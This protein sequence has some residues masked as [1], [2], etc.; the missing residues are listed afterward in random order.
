MKVTRT[1]T[2]DG[3]NPTEFEQIKA[4]LESLRE[5]FPGWEIIYNPLVNR[6]TAVRTDDVEKLA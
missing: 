2:I 4:H 1:I 6:A 3:D 5:K